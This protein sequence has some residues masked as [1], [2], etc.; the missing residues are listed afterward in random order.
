MA[1]DSAYGLLFQE[2]YYAD[3]D[4]K[5]AEAI[6]KKQEEDEKARKYRA[7]AMQGGGR[8]GLIFGAQQQG[9]A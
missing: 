5:R 7:G 9:V 8:I 4:K 2:Q 3:E 1:A 6:R